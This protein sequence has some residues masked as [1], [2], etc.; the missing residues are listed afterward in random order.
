MRAPD[1]HKATAPVAL[2]FAIL[3]VSDSRSPARDASG[4]LLDQLAT[5]AG[6]R[7]HRRALVRD[8]VD[9]IRAATAEALAL[10]EVD[11]LLVTGGTGLAPRDVTPEALAPLFEKRIPGFGELFRMLS[12][13]EIGSAA[14]L[15][16]ADAGLVE[17]KPVFLLPGST[18]ACRLAMERLVLPEA[19]HL[20]GLARPERRHAA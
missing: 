8:E 2:G 1:E 9:Q 18:A 6:H 16:R 10:P 4:D 14:M 19:G 5:Q 15:S 11:V 3:T 7:V 12:H 13:Q 20:V 17:G